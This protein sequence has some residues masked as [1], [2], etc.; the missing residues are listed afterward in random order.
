MANLDQQIEQ[1]EISIEEAKNLVE[2]SKSLDRLTNNKDFKKLI[3]DKYFKEEAS[4]LVLLKADAE[5]QG[6]KEQRDIIRQIDA[7][8]SLRIYFQTIKQLGQM[9]EN[10]IASDEAT[11]EELLAEQL[12]DE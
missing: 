1:I 11:R 4:R 2:E 7:I 10:S 12:N 8:G 3:L 9:A 6:E 5:M